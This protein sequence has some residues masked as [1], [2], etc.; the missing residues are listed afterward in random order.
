MK[1]RA[2]LAGP[3]VFLANAVEIGERKVEICARYGIEGRFPLDN[4]APEQATPRAMGLLISKLNEEMVDGCDIVLANLTPFRSPSIDP[5]TAFEIGYA[6]AQGKTI[7]GYT[8]ADGTLAERTRK[9]SGL[10][11]EMRRDREGYEIEDF[12]LADNLMIIGAIAAGDGHLV[13]HEA[14][15]LSAMAAFEALVRKVAAGLKG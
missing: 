5:G 9:F 3:D 11:A 15:D 6:R 2:Y 14:A 8:G 10:P 12:G 4:V 7:H 1:L 13:V